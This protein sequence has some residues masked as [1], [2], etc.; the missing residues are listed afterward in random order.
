MRRAFDEFSKKHR[1]YSEV[2][3]RIV[4]SDGD[5]AMKNLHNFVRAR[6]V[7]DESFSPNAG[8]NLSSFIEPCLDLIEGRE[9]AVQTDDD[10]WLDALRDSRH[11]ESSWQSEHLRAV[12]AEADAPDESLDEQAAVGRTSVP[13]APR[14]VAQTHANQHAAS[15]PQSMGGRGHHGLGNRIRLHVNAGSWA[16]RALSRSRQLEP[17]AGGREPNGNR[18]NNSPSYFRTLESRT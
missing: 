11:K 7:R 10:A 2:L 3:I 8:K 16:S 15:P 18:P 4:W 6:T 13:S 14:G 17:N 1:E 5:G 12:V 9:L